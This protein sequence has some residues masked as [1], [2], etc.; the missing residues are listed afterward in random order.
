MRLSPYPIRDRNDGDVDWENIQPENWQMNFRKL[1]DP[2]EELAGLKSTIVAASVFASIAL[3]LISIANVTFPFLFENSET[4]ILLAFSA[5]V[6]FLIAKLRGRDLLRQEPGLFLFGFLVVLLLLSNLGRLF[7]EGYRSEFYSTIFLVVV[8]PFVIFTLDKVA[9]MHVHWMTASPYLDRRTMLSLRTVWSQRF[10]KGL[11]QPANM[12]MGNRC[13]NP[14]QVNELMVK[15]AWYPLGLIS[16]FLLCFAGIFTAQLLGGES[17]AQKGLIL[18][19][20]FSLIAATLIAIQ[21]PQYPLTVLNGVCLFV[22]AMTF[23][24]HPG[25]IQYPNKFNYRMT[26]FFGAI[27]SLSFAVNSFWFPW[28]TVSFFSVDSA[29][30]LI[31]NIAVQFVVV[32]ALPSVLL[33]AFAIIALSRTLNAFEILCE[34]RG[35]ENRALLANPD[36]TEFDGYVNRMQRSPTSESDCV[37]VGFHQSKGFP[38]LIPTELVASHAHVLGGSGSRKTGLGLATLAAQL[39]K[40]NDRLVVIIDPKG[41]NAFFNS[42]KKWTEQEKRKFKWF[43]TSANKSTYLFNP[44]GQAAIEHFSLSELVG[45][46]ILSFNLFH[47]S[48]YGRGWF[49]QASKAALEDA[50]KLKREGKR[51]DTFALFIEHLELAIDSDREL[52]RAAKQV[53]YMMRSLAEFPQLN[54]LRDEN[55]KPHSACEH[56][57]DMLDAIKQN[58]VIYFHFDSTTDPSTAGELSRAAIYSVVAAAKVYANETNQPPKVTIIVD[59][60]QSVIASNISQVI[61]MARSQGVSFVFSHQTREQLKL[62]GGKDLRESLDSSTQVKMFFGVSVASYDYIQ[63]LSGEVGY[64]DATWKQYT[65]DLSAGNAS[66]HYALGFNGDPAIADIKAERGPR[67]TTNDIQDASASENTCILAVTRKHKVAQ[68]NGAF[69][70]NIDYPITP[71]QYDD[72]TKMRWPEIGPETVATQPHWPSVSGET[73]PREEPPQYSPSAGEDVAAI[74]KGIGDKKL[75]DELKK[76]EADPTHRMKIDGEDNA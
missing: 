55:G 17:L 9:T 32:F 22:N 3:V 34:S 44:L 56:A 62:S 73:K 54:Q 19:S 1:R 53:L 13:G 28:A 69:P 49:T 39:I 4:L 71:K 66:M 51:P 68:L 10:K 64:V 21:F 15:I 65:A 42:A 50:A 25:T 74:L 75:D 43:T 52:Q 11:F 18:A 58:Q 40:R 36:W 31:A 70:I 26:L 76:K 59:E 5:V 41:D 30:G 8:V 45:F 72:N 35:T 46:L 29:S 37:W 7:A 57:I 2:V 16:V 27:L 48:D 38:M 20:G 67:L 23:P 12:A 60:A 33:A 14:E 63:K 61:D 47:G 6:P 24:K